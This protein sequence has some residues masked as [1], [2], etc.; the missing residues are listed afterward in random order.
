MVWQQICLSFTV[1]ANLSKCWKLIL[2][3]ATLSF[4]VRDCPLPGCVW[5]I[6]PISRQF[7]RFQVGSVQLSTNRK[8]QKKV[9]P[10]ICHTCSTRP[11][12]NEK[13][14]L[15][16]SYSCQRACLCHAVYIVFTFWKNNNYGTLNTVCWV[17]NILSPYAALSEGHR[18]NP[19]ESSFSEKRCKYSSHFKSSK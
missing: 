13:L 8:I 3:L 7:A 19:L 10:P 12:P 11:I 17:Y 15:P 4:R 18:R 9:A 1:C 5:G 2:T 14:F 6:R 16:L